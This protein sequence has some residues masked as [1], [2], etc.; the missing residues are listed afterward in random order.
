M[1]SLQPQDSGFGLRKFVAGLVSLHLPKWKVFYAFV[2]EE[3][4]VCIQVFY[5]V[6]GQFSLHNAETVWFTLIDQ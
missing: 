3:Q 5:F 6:I 1:D 4:H 2:Y